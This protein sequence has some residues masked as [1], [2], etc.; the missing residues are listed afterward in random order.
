MGLEV[1]CLTGG[2]GGRNTPGKH[3]VLLW[4]LGGRLRLGP[5][6]GLREPHTS[7]PQGLGVQRAP[8]EVGRRGIA[9]SWVDR[10]EESKGA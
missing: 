5:R 6:V 9:P 4:G 10:Q 1:G 7:S 2:G 3:G 8:K